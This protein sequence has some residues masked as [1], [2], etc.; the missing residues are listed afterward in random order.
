MSYVSLLLRVQGTKLVLACRICAILAT[1]FLITTLLR[2]LVT[3]YY[4]YTWG[5][6]KTKVNTLS[7]LRPGGLFQSAFLFSP[8]TGSRSDLAQRQHRPD[9]TCP[10]ICLPFLASLQPRHT[11]MCHIQ[12]TKILYGMWL[13]IAGSVT[14]V[15]GSR[16]SPSPSRRCASTALTLL[17]QN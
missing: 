15:G 12:L 2:C 17:N 6:L 1:E 5:K 9:A 8:Q 4:K 11:F 14:R 3:A 10:K 16:M 13:F 7:L